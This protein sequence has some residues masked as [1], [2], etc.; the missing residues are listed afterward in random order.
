M[1]AVVAPARTVTTPPP[2]AAGKANVVFEGSKL[3]SA[4]A[5][6]PASEGHLYNL[7]DYV[8][9][10]HTQAVLGL[11]DYA[12]AL[13]KD[14]PDW[15]ITQA[16]G[17]NVRH[18]GPLPTKLLEDLRD[19]L[20]FEETV[21]GRRVTSDANIRQL[22][23]RD[24]ATEAIDEATALMAVFEETYWPWVTR[25]VDSETAVAGAALSRLDEALHKWDRPLSAL[26]ALFE[27]CE[28]LH[29]DVDDRWPDLKLDD[30]EARRAALQDLLRT[31]IARVATHV[32]IDMNPDRPDVFGWAFFRAHQD[33]LDD[34]LSGQMPVRA[35]LEE[36]LRLLVNATD[37]ASTRLRATVRRQ[38]VSVLGSFWSEPMLMLLQ[39]SGAALVIGLTRK[40]SDLL[41]VF[42]RV[43][44]GL[45]DTS[46]QHV[47]DVTLAALALDD[48]LIGISTGKINRSRRHLQTV[49]ALE[50]MGLSPD[51]IEDA[52][53]GEPPSGVSAKVAAMLRVISFGHLE[54]VFVAAWMVPAALRR[55]AT[56][57]QNGLGLRVAD[58]IK[59][60][61]D[62]TD[63]QQGETVG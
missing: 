43:W 59:N 12:Q 60:F 57:P 24:V 6:A 61:D 52:E 40:R 15:I 36:R 31:P 49:A 34:V 32:D 45:L 16:R 29:R 46:A 18:L 4:D 48:S 63:A 25:V 7:V 13:A 42:E 51:D 10:A 27:Q 14:L 39:L 30:L 8:G 19:G 23:A 26:R 9:L 2:S 11:H 1:E 22:V 41:G 5:G 28:A 3:G 47:L 50:G 62:A 54:E 33:L 44:D 35:D 37:R 56:L 20:A 58:L 38:H 53:L 17:T 55:G 21:E